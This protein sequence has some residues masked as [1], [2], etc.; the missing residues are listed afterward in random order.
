LSSAKSPKVFANGK[1][2]IR[3]LTVSLFLISVVMAALLV[4]QMMTQPQPP[5]LIS[6]DDA[7]AITKTEAKW[8]EQRIQ[9]VGAILLHIKENGYAFVVEEST[10]QDTFR[11]VEKIDGKYDGYYLWKVVLESG[12]GSANY[13]EWESW[14][15]ARTGRTM[16]DLLNASMEKQ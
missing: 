11:V 10:L 12:G 15:D 13:S 5:N 4:Y 3:I 7:I 1:N 2:G 14:V 6:K 9:N 16:F 8:D